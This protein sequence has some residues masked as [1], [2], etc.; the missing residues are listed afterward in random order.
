MECKYG[1][2]N[3][4]VERKSNYC[5]E[6]CYSKARVVTRRKRLKELSI[7]FLGGKCGLCNYNKC[8]RSLDFHHLD[9]GLKSFGIASSGYSHSWAKIKEELKKCILVC[10]NCHGEIHEGFY[11]IE[12]L[13]EIQSD[14]LKNGIDL[15]L[16][17]APETKYISCTQCGKERKYYKNHSKFCV[18]CYNLNR[19][20]VE[21]PDHKELKRLIKENG[22][23]GTGRIFGVSDNAIRKWEN[24][25]SQQNGKA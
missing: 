14:Q 3:N 7:S 15:E 8:V 11:N 4:V 19:R 17:K 20:T 21:R 25:F 1:A 24:N 22:Y 16:P 12:L 2:C 13:N 6:K 5:S 18:E 9:A 10:S 23:R